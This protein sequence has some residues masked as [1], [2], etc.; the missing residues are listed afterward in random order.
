[1]TATPP[2]FHRDDFEW[3]QGKAEALPRQWLRHVR[4]AY[5]R[6]YRRQGRQAAN[7]YMLVASERAGA[8]P[9]PLSADD[10]AI[11]AKAERMAERCSR[12]TLDAARAFANQQGVA[13]PEVDTVAGEHNRL[14]CPR[15]WRRRLRTM[16]GRHVEGLGRDL[17]LV[18]LGRDLYATDAGVH[19]RRGQRRRN[20]TVLEQMEAVNEQGQKY[21]LQELADL[22]VASPQLRRNE[23]MT[24]IAG[25]EH[26]ARQHHHAGEFWTVTAPSRYHAA[27][28]VGPKGRQWADDNP[29]YQGTTPREAQGYLQ[30][31]WARAR[32][33]LGRRGIHPYGFRVCEPQHDGTPHWHLLLFLPAWQRRR[34][35][36]V[37]ARYATAEDRGELRKGWRGI[38]PRFDVKAIDWN[39]GSAA[40][41]IAKY[42]AKN[43]DGFGVDADLF[44]NDPKAAA[45]RVDAWASTWGIRQFQQIGG[46]SVTVWRELRRLGEGAEVPAPVEQAARAAD[47]GD[48]CAYVEAMGGAIRQRK[49]RPI[50][51]LKVWS[52]QPGRYGEPKG[53][54]IQ[55]VEAGPVAVV[56]RLHQWE[57]RRAESGA[58]ENENADGVLRESG[59]DCG[60]ADGRGGGAFLGGYHGSD[61]AE[62]FSDD[63][64]RGSQSVGDRPGSDGQGLSGA[65]VRGF[66]AG[67]SRPWSPVN[68]C[69]E[70]ESHVGPGRKDSEPERRNRPP[71]GGDPRAAEGAKGPDR[72]QRGAGPGAP[73]GSG[74]PHWA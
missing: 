39:K 8:F 11:R 36:H 26:V 13:P 23:L 61:R 41:Y 22:S 34:A 6:R 63:V 18:R 53:E 16:H 40:G 59:V 14:S 47:A 55:G 46:P 64:G 62:R 21:T 74:G 58:G 72:P 28:M 65:G 44:G 69:T 67:A 30:K 2:A 24:R 9:L 37:M 52:D 20:Q 73:G 3:L 38:R 50:Q 17:G 15:W 19:R 25:F 4:P 1:M 57:I 5:S 51:L 71:V 45:A 32:A 49:E 42:I 35:R 43:I 60:A 66:V 10:E 31:V 68:N 48:W 54:Q 27:R 56:T 7:L 29:K 12:A 33:A 70:G